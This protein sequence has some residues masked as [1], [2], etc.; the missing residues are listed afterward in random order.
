MRTQI[1]IFNNIF[2]SNLCYARNVLKY[3]LKIC[4]VWCLF[5]FIRYEINEILQ[6][7]NIYLVGNIIN[8]QYLGRYALNVVQFTHI[9]ILNINI[10]DITVN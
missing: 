1:L 7:N 10:N 2:Y 6:N 4:F 8:Y 3:F 9:M 5:L